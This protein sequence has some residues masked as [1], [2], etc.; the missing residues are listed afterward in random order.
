MDERV[1]PSGIEQ[2][3]GK[4][5]HVPGE[6]G[7][8]LDRQCIG[9]QRRSLWNPEHRLWIMTPEFEAVCT[10]RIPKNA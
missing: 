9:C 10:H 6:L 3:F 8:T 4:F 1:L 2:C 5:R 7:Q